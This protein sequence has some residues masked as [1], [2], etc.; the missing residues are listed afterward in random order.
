[1]S[2]VDELL[3]ARIP[4]HETNRY[5][6]SVNIRGELVIKALSS[7]RVYLRPDEAIELMKY[8][9]ENYI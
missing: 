9:Q 7:G 4:M 1:M 6:F 8:I 5:H 3:E 2:K